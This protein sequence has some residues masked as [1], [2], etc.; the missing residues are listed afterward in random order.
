MLNLWLNWDVSFFSFCPL[1]VLFIKLNS[2]H[3]NVVVFS[4][5]SASGM[6][7]FTSWLGFYVLASQLGIKLAPITTFTT[8]QESLVG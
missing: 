3:F 7:P 1:V 5:V 6:F 2:A 4:A 8:A